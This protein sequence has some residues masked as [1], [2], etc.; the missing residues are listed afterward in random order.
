MIYGSHSAA[1]TIS[2]SGI[3]FF[4][5][6]SLIYVGKAAPPNPTRPE[7]RIIWIKS[8][9]DSTFGGLQ[10]GLIVCWKSD[11]MRTASTGVP[12]AETT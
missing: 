4:G 5:G 3:L 1:L 6:F 2:V 12:L 10:K 9:N 7:S 8:S 11:S